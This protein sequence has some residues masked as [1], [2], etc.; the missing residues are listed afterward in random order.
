MGTGVNVA[1]GVGVRVG[2]KVGVEVLLTTNVA[3][4]TSSVALVIGVAGVQATT[5]RIISSTSMLAFVFIVPY[6]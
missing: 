1:G 4:A 3:G 2:K 5:L 6:L